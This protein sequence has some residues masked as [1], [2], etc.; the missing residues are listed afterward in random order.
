[1]WVEAKRKVTVKREN[2]TE[3]TERMDV[4][5]LGPLI[6]HV[7]KGKF[8]LVHE[9]SGMAVVAVTDR[10]DAKRIGEIFR[11]KCLTAMRERS[12][13]AMLAKI[14]LD[15][16]RWMLDCNKQGKLVEP[17]FHYEPQTEEE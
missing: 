11:V 16:G 7:N 15:V 13:E 8:Q 12:K 6:I 4:L 14:P 10:E 5:L 2:E 1:M 9:P 3:T 17:P